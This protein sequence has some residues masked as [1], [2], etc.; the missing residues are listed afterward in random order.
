M[1]INDDMSRAKSD[2]TLKDAL[3][4]FLQIYRQTAVRINMVFRFPGGRGIRAVDN[5]V[6]GVANEL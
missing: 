4:L 3:L 5:T 6:T 1:T 2:F